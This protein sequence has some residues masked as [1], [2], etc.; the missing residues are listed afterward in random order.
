MR[1]DLLDDTS[2]GDQVDNQDDYRDHQNE[3]NECTTNVQRESEQ[4]KDEKYNKYCPKHFYLLFA[5]KPRGCASGIGA[6]MIVTDW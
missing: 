3:V 1:R 5:P 6:E 4:P 2:S